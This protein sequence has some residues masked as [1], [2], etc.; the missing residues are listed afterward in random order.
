[1]EKQFS[2]LERITNNVHFNKYP[3]TR[4]STATGLT[5]EQCKIII[6]ETS[7][8]YFAQQSKGLFHG[9]HVMKF[10]LKIF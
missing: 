3:R 5:G 2:A 7:L 6:S 1:M 8:K 10:M 4:E 9:S